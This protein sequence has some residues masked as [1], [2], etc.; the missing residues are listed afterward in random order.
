MNESLFEQKDLEALRT[1][2]RNKIGLEV[3]DDGLYEAAISC[4]KFTAGKLLR[5]ADL[6]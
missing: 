4:I 1:V 5:Q 2:L 3:D 6:I